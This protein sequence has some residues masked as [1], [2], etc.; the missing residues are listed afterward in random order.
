MRLTINA[1]G[2]MGKPVH[3]AYAAVARRGFVPGGVVTRWV[4]YTGVR[5]A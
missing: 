3:L 1:L 2:P 5:S 4:E